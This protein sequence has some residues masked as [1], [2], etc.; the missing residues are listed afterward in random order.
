MGGKAP[1]FP[2]SPL[3]SP[4]SNEDDILALATYNIENPATMIEFIIE[5]ESWLNFVCKWLYYIWGGG[6]V[7]QSIGHIDIYRI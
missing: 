6:T 4:S 5:Y 3:D 2:H 1:Y 7:K